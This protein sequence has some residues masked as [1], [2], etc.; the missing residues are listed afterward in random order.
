[1][2]DLTDKT[3][4]TEEDVRAAGNGS[5][6]QINMKALVTPLAADTLRD[7]RISVV[8]EDSVTADEASLAPRA[9]VRSIAVASDHSG[10][11][12]RRAMVA[13]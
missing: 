1:M 5:T 7:R 2:A 6:L 12:L 8:S 9:E 10:V 3:L 4:I 11:A 13:N